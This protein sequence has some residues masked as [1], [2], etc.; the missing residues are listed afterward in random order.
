MDQTL[1]SSQQERNSLSATP[2]GILALNRLGFGPRPGDLGAFQSLGSTADQRL[3]SY[4]EQQLN[5]IA[6]ADTDCEARLASAGYKTINKSLT[7]LWTDHHVNYGDYTNRTLPYRET[8]LFTFLRAVFSKRQLAEVM[9][10]FWHNHF[11]IYALDYYSAPIF[12]H[13][14]R[15]IIRPHMLGNFREFLDAVT[16]STA[17]LTYLDNYTNSNAGPNENHARELFELHTLGA[18]NYRGVGRQDQ[19]P[20]DSQGRPI[21]YVDDDVYEAARCLTGWTIR[22]QQNNP[23]IGN[24]GEFYYRADWHDRFQKHVLGSFFA[25]DQAN[26]VDGQ[27]LLDLLA[28]HPGTAHYVSLKLCQRFISD[29]PSASI[30]S[31]T[32]ALFHEKRNSPQQ[33]TEVLRHILNSTEFKNSW[34]QKTKRPYE[35]IASALRAS[36]AEYSFAA[37]DPDNGSIYWLFEQLGQPLFRRR[38]PDGYPD[39]QVYWLNSSSMVGAWRLLNWL[40]AREDSNGRLRMDVL[41]QTPAQIRS[42]VEIADFWIYRVL[43]RTIPAADRQHIIDFM[44]QGHHPDLD[45]PLD[46]DLATKRR[47]S[48]LVALLFM[49]PEFQYR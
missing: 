7:Q 5:P 32:A 15:D 13:H 19:V 27:Q 26:M 20:K 38:S 47:L 4:I 8:E 42:A 25:P 22:N 39:K 45:L 34:G 43:G 35:M 46:T 37:D 12:I 44:A 21:G 41:S 14:D 40:S 28:F 31:S 30:V 48:S 49:S 36:A 10:D 16:K 24:T 3:S 1:P 17:M 11:N 6:I 23:E 9:A 2:L 29:K 18:I 33:I